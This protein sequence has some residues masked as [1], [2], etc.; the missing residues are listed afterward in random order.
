MITVYLLGAFVVVFIALS[1]YHTVKKKPATERLLSLLSTTLVTLLLRQV[2]GEVKGPIE[3]RS[4]QAFHC[5]L[6]L[7]WDVDIGGV[8]CDSYVGLI[9][10][11][12]ATFLALGA[13]LTSKRYKLEN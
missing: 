2:A 1:L 11:F 3:V 10:A 9:V 13:Y 8:G 4:Y 12:L 5:A 7:C 6:T